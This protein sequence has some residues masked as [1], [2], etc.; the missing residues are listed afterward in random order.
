MSPG[1]SLSKEALKTWQ[2]FD[3][4]KLSVSLFEMDMTY[5][6]LGHPFEQINPSVFPTTPPEMDLVF[7][8]C[9]QHLTPKGT[10]C[11]SSLP[12]EN[13]ISRL[14]NRWHP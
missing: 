5:F 4:M 9:H 6:R 12:D 1:S 14:V 7:E 3:E 2:A 11:S 8:D 10:W 13:T